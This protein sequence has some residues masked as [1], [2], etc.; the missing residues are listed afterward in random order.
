MQGWKGW[1]QLL[2]PSRYAQGSPERPR[3]GRGAF[4]GPRVLEDLTSQAGRRL[5]LL[6]SGAQCSFWALCQSQSLAHNCVSLWGN[7]SKFSVPRGSN[8]V[9]LAA[10]GLLGAGSSCQ[11]E[12]HWRGLL[13]S[14]SYIQ[15]W[16]SGLTGLG[17][18]SFL[19]SLTSVPQTP[20]PCGSSPKKFPSGRHSAPRQ[21]ESC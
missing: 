17:S 10:P 5:L 3:E 7:V 18:L 2:P 21:S 20:A 16:A 14:S 19:S 15:G 1:L 12:I 11:L 6:C 4:W 8:Y 13:L 9:R